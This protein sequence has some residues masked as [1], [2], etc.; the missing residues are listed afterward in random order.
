MYKLGHLRGQMLPLSNLREIK[1]DGQLNLECL[2]LRLRVIN[3][4]RIRL[5]K[6]AES[7]ALPFTLHNV[8]Q[9]GL[10]SYQGGAGGLP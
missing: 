5:C 3:R 9:R 10:T 1:Q 7:T 4:H 8:K 6:G 2:R